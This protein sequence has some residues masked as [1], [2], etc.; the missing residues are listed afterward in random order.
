MN[1]DFL[2]ELYR[3]ENTKSTLESLPW[4]NVQGKI[5]LTIINS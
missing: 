4:F 5:K 2:R 1:G 3:K